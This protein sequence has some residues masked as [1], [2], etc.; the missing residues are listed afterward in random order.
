M[1]T[2]LIRYLSGWT[3]LQDVPVPTVCTCGCDDTGRPLCVHGV[4][5]L[6][7]CT[8]MWCACLW[9]TYVVCVPVHEVCA[10]VYLLYILWCVPVH[11]VLVCTFCTYGVYLYYI[12]IVYGYFVIVV[13]DIFSM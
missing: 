9:Y 5:V 8:C 10:Y 4:F 7:V 12:F 6:G 11:R 1:V 13:I 2:D 3:H